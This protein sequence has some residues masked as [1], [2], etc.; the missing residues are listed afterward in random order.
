MNRLQKKL[1]M[2]GWQTRIITNL[3][4]M[5]LVNFGLGATR[6]KKVAGYGGG[7]R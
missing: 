4:R 5:D 6:A 1:V 3:L 7:F 2:E